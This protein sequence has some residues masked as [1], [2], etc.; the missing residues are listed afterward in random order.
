M[1]IFEF[2]A[3][4]AAACWALTSII[5]AGPAAHLG[6][7]AFTRIRMTIV[8]AMLVG[9]VAVAGTWQTITQEMLWPIVL[10]GVVGIFLGDSALFATMNRMGPRR[11]SILFATS[12]PMAVLLGWL[13]LDETLTSRE[14]LGVAV[15]FLGV[16]LAI[17]FGKRKAQL[18]HWETVKGPLWIGVGIG[19]IAGL[20]QAAGSLIAKPVMD[21]GADAVAVSA[22]RVTVSVCCFY[23]ALMLP[24]RTM[25]AKG[26]LNV[27]I[28]LLMALSG[29]LAMALGMTLVLFA[30]S[31]G[32]VGI[33]STLSGTAPALV[34]PLIWMHTRERPAAGAWLGAFLVVAGSALIFSA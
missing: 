23:M 34:L 12:A 30:L 1:N 11:T 4:A 26:K 24:G 9:W 13:F 5:N 17:V 22:I 8:M 15:V 32:D 18:H 20:A 27:N 33:V 21:A 16:T 28:L 31:G 3:I 10:S 29:F 14:M 7:I 25:V 19:L 6:A 2:A